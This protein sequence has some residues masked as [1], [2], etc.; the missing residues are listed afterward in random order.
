MLDANPAPDALARPNLPT[1]AIDPPAIAGPP[2]LPGDALFAAARALLPVLESGRPLDAATLRNA[3]TD[4]F[5]AS[6]AGGGWVWK[7]A[8]EA[9]EAACVL[10][11]Q[12]Y[13]RGMRRT[14]GAGSGRAA[15][16]AGDARG[17]SRRWSPRTPGAPRNRSG[18]SSSRP[19]CRWPTPHCRP[20]RSGRAMWCWNP[21]PAPACSP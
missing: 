5:G 8:Y 21:R 15:P 20:P 10:F 16:H 12:R 9:A 17:R 11:L 6:D 4:A 7:D 14:C 3:M 2:S 1:D 13:G 19:R 18:S